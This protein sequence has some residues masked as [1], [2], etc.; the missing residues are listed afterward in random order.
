MRHTETSNKT[1]K[2]FFCLVSLH[3][4][5]NKEPTLQVFPTQPWL[6]SPT[7]TSLLW[8]VSKLIPCRPHCIFCILSSRLWK[9]MSI[10]T[11]SLTNSKHQGRLRSLQT[12]SKVLHVWIGTCR[13]ITIQRIQDHEPQWLLNWLSA[14]QS[15][16]W[17]D[18]SQQVKEQICTPS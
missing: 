13:K 11:T 8:A 5:K 15:I 1:R 18:I 14:N 4:L 2:N 16:W 12:T 7:S 3:V 17:R 10:V 9:R 6:L